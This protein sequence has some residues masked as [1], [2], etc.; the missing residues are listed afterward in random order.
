MRS[1]VWSS[2]M[3]HRSMGQHPAGT[4]PSAN[5]RKRPSDRSIRAAARCRRFAKPFRS[6]C[7]FGRARA[8]AKKPLCGAPFFPIYALAQ[9]R[10]CLWSRVGWRGSDKRPINRQFQPAAGGEPAN[11]VSNGGRD[12]KQRRTGLFRLCRPSKGRRTEEACLSCRACGWDFPVQSMA[13]STTRRRPRRVEPTAQHLIGTSPVRA[14]AR[15]DGPAGRGWPCPLAVR[16]VPPRE[17]TTTCP[18]T[19]SCQF[20]RLAAPKGMPP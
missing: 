11:P 9:F 2:V 19:L 5:A 8:A 12:L 17:R 14:F 3:E 16:V 18:R 7:S 4:D 20:R 1:G 15:V 10:T 6:L 13:H